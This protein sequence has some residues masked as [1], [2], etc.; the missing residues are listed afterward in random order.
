MHQQCSRYWAHAVGNPPPPS[1]CPHGTNIQERE[2]EPTTVV[3]SPP[4][5]FQVCPPR[6]S[7][8]NQGPRAPFPGLSLSISPF[9]TAAGSFSGPCP[10]QKLQRV[11]ALLVLGDCPLPPRALFSSGVIWVKKLHLS[12]RKARCCRGHAK[13]SFAAMCKACSASTVLGSAGSQG[14]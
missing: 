3:S 1:S 12:G 10:L 4:G 6:A 13:P 2:A 8:R 14:G 11:L 7:Q 5:M 9:I